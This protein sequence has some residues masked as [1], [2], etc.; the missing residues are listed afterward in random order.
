MFRKFLHYWKRIRIQ[1]LSVFTHKNRYIFLKEQLQTWFE[2]YIS[3]LIDWSQSKKFKLLRLVESELALAHFWISVVDNE[4]A[5]TGSNITVKYSL[6]LSHAS[7]WIVSHRR[8]ATTCGKPLVRTQNCTD[9]QFVDCH[10]LLE[11]SVGNFRTNSQQFIFSSGFSVNFWS[12][13]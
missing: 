7:L 5:N 13:L 11:S 12:M 4:P 6:E 9:Q 2:S 10:S 3:Q 1:S 8:Y